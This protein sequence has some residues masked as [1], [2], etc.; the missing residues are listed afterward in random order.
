[1]IRYFGQTKEYWLEFG[2]LHDW[3]DIY[4]AE[5]RR[6]PPSEAFLAGY[7]D[8]HSDE[9]VP[10]SEEYVEPLPEFED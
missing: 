8:Y 6:M 5:L 7:F 10:E 1:L 4:G 3:Q 2:T 9:E